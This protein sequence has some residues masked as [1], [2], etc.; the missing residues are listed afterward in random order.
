L[1][2]GA[3]LVVAGL[4]AVVLAVGERA[5]GAPPPPVSYHPAPA[6]PNIVFVLTDDLTWDLLPYMPH[7]RALQRD[8]MTFRQFMVSDSLCCSSRATIFTGDFP[9]NTRVLG[10]E[11][12]SGGY[13]AFR[14]AGDAERS[15]A[16]AL[17]GAGYRTALWGKYLNEYQPIAPGRDPGWDEWFAVNSAYRGFGYRA[18]DDGFPVHVGYRPRNYLTSVLVRR[19]V[20]FI[21][22]YGGG[23]PFFGM[24]STFAPHKPAIP[25]PRDRGRFRH[26]PLPREPGYDAQNTHPP[27][28]LGRRPPVTWAQ[29][30]RLVR[31][32]RQRVRS[33]QAVDRMIGRIRAT[34]RATG[35]ARNTYLVFTSDNGL[36]LGQHRLMAGKRTAFD[37]D[38]RVPL[39]IAGPGVPPGSMTSQVTGTVDLAPTFE[40]WAHLGVDPSRDGRSLTPQLRGR[41]PRRWQRALLIEHTTD[42]SRPSDPDA[43]GRAGGR[44][45]T[46]AAL[47]TR[48]T[49]YVEYANGER[50]FYDR[51]SDPAELHNIVARLSPTRLARLSAALARYRRCHGLEQCAAAARAAP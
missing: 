29:H 23:Q 2:I 51:R 1:L 28:W 13:E 16:V 26:L 39:I 38:I 12:P 34:L 45:S 35:V 11:A 5:P 32:F 44:P 41:R 27:G 15:V 6:R 36:H 3:V 8:G 43:Q 7:V 25:A 33:V 10:N 42:T 37:E 18:S 14:R 22:A 40:R 17:Q 31:E 9:H 50:E 20:R 21:R 19:A 30:R 46:Y 24:V 48:W 47:R 49:T 4:T